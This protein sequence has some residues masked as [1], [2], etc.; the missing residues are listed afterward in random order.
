VNDRISALFPCRSFSSSSTGCFLYSKQFIIAHQLRCERRDLGV[1][2]LRV[3]VHS[4]DQ[5]TE[6][7]LI[8]HRYPTIWK[9]QRASL[10][11]RGLMDP[12]FG[13]AHELTSQKFDGCLVH[14]VV[15]TC[16][17]ALWFILSL[18]ATI[19]ELGLEADG[20][21]V[22]KPGLLESDEA[23]PCSGVMYADDILTL[24]EVDWKTLPFDYVLGW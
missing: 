10:L 22:A 23:D 5:D 14:Q 24:H 9:A 13:L 1:D 12:R 7:I 6:A 16:F 15:V 17:E 4:K 11:H 8:T 3:L 21:L 2:V 18:G 20:A 19:P